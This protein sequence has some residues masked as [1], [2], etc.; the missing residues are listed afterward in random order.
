[1]AEYQVN[2]VKV[3]PVGNLPA[4]LHGL[5]ELRLNEEA[6]SLE[7]YMLM[8]DQTV[9]V[10]Q[11]FHFKKV[12]PNELMDGDLLRYDNPHITADEFLQLMLDC[13]WKRG[14][15][16]TSMGTEKAAGTDSQTGR[17]LAEVRKGFA[18]AALDKLDVMNISLFDHKRRITLLACGGGHAFEVD[19]RQ[20]P[21]ISWQ[22]SMD[23]GDFSAF[24]PIGAKMA[25][26]IKELI[27]G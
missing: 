27:D 24:L 9:F 7:L 19:V 18:Q 16:P 22:A 10:A 23:A 1:M 17:M 21:G 13:A 8:P 25:Q 4:S 2:V 12:G 15:R 20:P 26:A 14:M 6:G 3:E 11:P 5:G